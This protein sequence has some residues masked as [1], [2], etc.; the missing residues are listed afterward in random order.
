MIKVVSLTS[1]G[2]QD[3][4]FNFCAYDELNMDCL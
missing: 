2:T 4:I 3:M 1:P